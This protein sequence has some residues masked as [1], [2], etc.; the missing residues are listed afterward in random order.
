MIE[1][2]HVV[3]YGRPASE[4]LA[5]AV[6]AA[7]GDDPLAP[8]TVVVSSNF[9]GL[10]SRRLLASGVLAPTGA[11][12]VGIANVS[13]VTPFRLAEQVGA[14]LLLESRPITNPVLGAAVR[15]V[16]ATDPGPFAPVREHEATEAALAALFAELS[17]VDE[18]G[19]E[20]IL[21]E[22]SAAAELAVRYHRAI[23]GQLSG[24]HTE[25]DLALAAADRVDLSENAAATRHVIWYLPAPATTAL[26]QFLGRALAAA[27]SSTVIVG[28]TGVPDA[29][30][31]VWRT[32]AD[33]GVALPAVDA[34]GH[35]DAQVPAGDRIVSVT[36][37]AEEVREV[38]ARSLALIESGVAPDR[39][40]VFYPSPTPYLRIIEQQFE[41]A[42][43]MTNGPDPRR[44]TD[45]VAGRTL[46]AALD[47]DAERWR[48][49]R[50]MA[51][52]SGGPIRSG[53][54]LARPSAWDALTRR[55]GV[56]AELGDWR[57]KLTLL[58][59]TSR[60]R[61]DDIDAAVD[62]EG[63]RRGRLID[64]IADTHE[65]ESFL[66]TLVGSLRAVTGAS[67]WGERCAAAT[68]LLHALLGAEHLHASWPD[69]E[70]DAFAGVEAALVRLATLDEIEPRPSG[71]VFVRALRAE[72][73][74]ARGRRGRFGHGVLYGPISAAAGH[75]LDAVFVLGAVEGMLPASRRDD[76]MLPDR[77][78]TASL[79]QLEVRSMRLAHQ[80]R[81][82]LAALAAAPVGQRTITFPRGSLRSNRSALPSRWL[83]DTASELA[84]HTVHATDFAELGGDVVEEVRSFS[85]GIIASATRT[86]STSVDEFDLAMLAASEHPTTHP[87]ARVV[88]GGL[89]THRQRRSSRF[90]AYDGNLAGLDG[91]L[92]ERP[93]SPSRL[94][95]W[96]AC[97]FKYFLKHVLD[98]ADRDDPERLDDISALD[99]G[100][101]IHSILER[102]IDEAIRNGPPGPAIPWS[103]ADRRRLHEI[104]AEE[105]E[106]YRATGRT[107]RAVHWRLQQDVL[108]ELLDQFLVADNDFRAA[109]GATPHAVEM[110]LG[111]HSG[112]P[113][114]FELSNGRA[115]AMRGLADRVDTTADGVIVSDYKSG[116]QKKLDD[117]NADPFV[118]GRTL[119][120]AMYSEGA[121][122]EIG[123]SEA[124]AA[125]AA[126]WL[127]EKS[128]SGRV[129]YR[130]SDHLRA[131]F[132]EVL[133]AITD[134]IADGVFAATPGEWQL[135]FQTNEECAYCEFDSVCPRERG[136][137]A[138]AK[139]SSPELAVRVAL[140]PSTVEDAP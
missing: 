123:A 117:L 46:L 38:C 62:P 4:A 44:L 49:D 52:L 31:P 111:V 85:S 37:A 137:Q 108:A 101:L 9:I 128:G 16:L 77:L 106:R 78:R 70:R 105:S 135:F 14:G 79:D 17:N 89:E 124:S 125:S 109:R 96:A 82:F 45:S 63:W 139:A 116:Q 134:G 76:A 120:L 1:S 66:D 73:D 118:G 119:Q 13:F 25:R 136:E 65:L 2:V 94:E 83:L 12:P 75:D 80:Q 127:V 98:V 21:D 58:R 30:E 35:D 51:L 88:A 71:A 90:T 5:A 87:V 122:R 53:D 24:F 34:V 97:G 91:L 92:D 112:D 100:S 11:R 48:R 99:R 61:L 50:V 54:G 42:S 86:G 107:G 132:D 103:A 15:R 28:A 8:V 102:F 104:A 60:Q 41:A 18:A 40:G 56:V 22:G 57:A 133:S 64:E 39:I 20:S 95:T 93:M 36:D 126:Y 19:L 55:A 115:V 7:K 110:D 33:V 26:A 43:V 131:R 59:D 114:V 32:C 113:V 67:G 23:S 129:G 47:L 6:A 10:A 3:E 27:A 68:E 69:R 130:W 138:E 84:G 74:V 29:D 121:L 81:S 140:S 72:L